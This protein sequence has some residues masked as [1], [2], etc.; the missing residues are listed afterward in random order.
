MC[1][2]SAT[3]VGT[4]VSLVAWPMTA[5]AP[6]TGV[7]M[8]SATAVLLLG[9]PEEHETDHEG[10]DSPGDGDRPDVVRQRQ[11]AV[12]VVVLAE[13]GRHERE[14]HQVH[15]DRGRVPRQQG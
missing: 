12:R 6:R 15:V 4:R 1:T 10:A 5:S 3:T 9:A 13:G 8:V 7:E 14:P 2:S 11:V